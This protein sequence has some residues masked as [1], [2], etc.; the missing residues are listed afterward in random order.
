MAVNKVWSYPLTDISEWQFSGLMICLQA[1]G[2]VTVQ[3]DQTAAWGERVQAA[4]EGKPG[5]AGRD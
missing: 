3:V 4:V 1:G 2:Q 5:G